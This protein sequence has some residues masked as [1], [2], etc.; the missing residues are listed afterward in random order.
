MGVGYDNVDVKTAGQLGIPV[1]NIPDYGTEEVADTTLALILGL[2]RGTFF[3]NQKLSNGEI[4]QGKN[5]KLN[6]QKTWMLHAQS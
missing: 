2:F 3:S 6:S 1:C 5:V 4:I